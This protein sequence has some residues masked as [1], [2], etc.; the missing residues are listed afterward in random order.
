[1]QQLKDEREALFGFT[2]EDHSAWTNAVEHKHDSSFLKAIDQARNDPE[3][4]GIHVQN[5]AKL[6]ANLAEKS[7]D[8]QGHV[9]LSHLTEDG[10][11]VRMVDIG[12]KNATHRVAVAESK[13]V[14]PPEVI[15]A[16]EM[17]TDKTDLIGSKGP[18]FA[19]A[20]LAGIMAAK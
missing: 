6:Q 20:K 13:V 14:F 4:E 8:H 2:D 11:S 5:K 1:M 7:S 16:F 9:G 12:P 19:T 10:K 15:Q 3:D 17:T 18:I